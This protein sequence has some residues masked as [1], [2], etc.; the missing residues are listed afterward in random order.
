[1]VCPVKPVFIVP[2]MT[3]TS[4]ATVNH[5][6]PTHWVLWQCSWTTTWAVCQLLLIAWRRIHPHVINAFVKANSTLPSSAAVEHL[7]S[8]HEGL[9][10]EIVNVHQPW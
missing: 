1:M 5:K 2:M 9:S 6:M 4:S 7:F 10:E 8:A 3:M